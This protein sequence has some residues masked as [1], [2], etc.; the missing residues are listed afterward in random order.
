MYERARLVV[1][2]LRT[3]RDVQT[4]QNRTGNDDDDVADDDDASD[5]DGG[6]LDTDKHD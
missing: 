4:S 1:A 2:V 5:S 6:V 3:V